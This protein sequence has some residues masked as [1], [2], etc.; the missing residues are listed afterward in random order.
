MLVIDDTTLDKPYAR[1]M[2]LVT[3]H[4]SGKHH[5]VVLGINLITLVWTDGNAVLPCDCRIYDKP[6]QNAGARG[7]TKND[8]FVAMLATTKERGFAPTIV[9]FDSWYSSL[10]NLKTVRGYGWHFLTRLKS[11]RLVNP[12][13]EG[14][15]A[16]STIAIP[17]AGR[18]VHLKGFGFVSVFRTVAPNG[19][20]EHW[21]TSNLSMTEEQREQFAKEC[22]AIEQY[23]RGLKQCCG[24]ERAQAR[25]A[26]AQKC[27]IVLAIRAFVRLEA[28]RLSCGIAWYSAKTGIVREAIRAYLARPNITL[29]PNA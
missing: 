14:N 19:D 11:N 6:L 3:R 10:E 15:V 13:A 29:N 2:E 9:C 27:H 8:H 28:Y 7:Q 22:F 23:H 4:W 21:A 17:W 5:Q 12:D 24:V 18:R 1:K 26:Q 16:V 25:K 20:V